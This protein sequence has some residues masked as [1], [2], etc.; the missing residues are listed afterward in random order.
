MY[1]RVQQLF[2]CNTY[3]QDRFE[4]PTVSPVVNNDHPATIAAF[5]QCSSGPLAAA[6]KGVKSSGVPS[7]FPV[8]MMAMITPYIATAS[9]N[10]TDTKF[11]DRIRGAFT[12]APN[13]ELPQR[14]MPLSETTTN[15]R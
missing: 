7:S 2:V 4:S 3:P 8:A 10:I 11:L 1:Q 5:C 12:A 15:K 13:M 6:L 9:Q 14:N